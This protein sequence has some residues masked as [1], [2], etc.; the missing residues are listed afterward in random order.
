[1]EIRSDITVMIVDD[2]QPVRKLLKEWLSEEFPHWVF[3]EASNGRE[4]IESCR[5]VTPEV[6]IMDINMPDM[7][8]IEATTRLKAA[9]P[10]MQVVV[11][12][13]HE[14]SVYKDCAVKAGASAYVPK[15]RL[16]EDL[17][18]ILRSLCHE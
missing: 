14:N 13:I 11:L 17:A 7:G 9:H 8:G 10:S 3:V 2:H 18:P 4:A 1:M 5:A 12:T 6:A 15:R 16:Y